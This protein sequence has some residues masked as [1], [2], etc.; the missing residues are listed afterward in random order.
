MTTAAVVL[1]LVEPMRLTEP[2]DWAYY[3]AATNFSQ[4]RL[5]ID[6]AL[7]NQQVA[8]ARLRGGELIQYV[9]IGAN[10]WA[11][12]KAPGTVFYMVPFKTLGIPRAANI[13]LLL[14]AVAVT[15]LVLKQLRDEKTACIGTVLLLA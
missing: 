12:E 5:V 4:G 3:Y 8:E 1:A 11:L 15:Y 6:G 13:L 10:Q 14:G 7:H 9:R 2:D